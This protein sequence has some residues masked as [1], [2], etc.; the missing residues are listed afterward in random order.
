MQAIDNNISI[1][2]QIVF[3]PNY[4]TKI[5]NGKKK[6]DYDA[7]IKRIAKNWPPNKTREVKRDLT[8]VF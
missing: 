6:I 4:P 2:N 7:R 3:K 1:V 5:V 8:K